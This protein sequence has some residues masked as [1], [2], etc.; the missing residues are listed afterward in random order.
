MKRPFL[1]ARVEILNLIISSLMTL[2]LIKE[3]SVNTGCDDKTVGCMFL[4][5]AGQNEDCSLLL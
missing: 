1:D 5:P 4:N 3:A 2:K